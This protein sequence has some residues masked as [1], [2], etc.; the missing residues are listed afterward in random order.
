MLV[1]LLYWVVFPIVAGWMVIRFIKKHSPYVPSPAVAALFSDHPL[2]R[3][4]FRAARREGD[5]IVWLGDFEKQPEAVDAI[6]LAKEEAQRKG[7]RASFVVFN[8]KAE[9]LEQVDS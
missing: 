3:R 8:D 9:I 5:V 1:P 7:E 4:W 6:Y 2:E